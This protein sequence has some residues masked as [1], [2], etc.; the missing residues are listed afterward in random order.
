[1]AVEHETGPLRG[2][3]AEAAELAG[4]ISRSRDGRGGVLLVEG[5]P[6]AGKSRLAEE[7]RTFAEHLAIR[8]L[9]GTGERERQSVPFSAL[10]G[11]LASGGPPL[12]GAADLR[13]LSES[14]EHRFWLVRTVQD[15]LRQAA[16]DGPLLVVIDDLQWCDAGTLLAL[17]ILPARLRSLPI[18]WLLAVRTGSPGA[19]VRATLARLADAGARTMR[20]DRLPEDAVAEIARDLLCAEPGRD[21]LDLLR[22]AE[23]LPELVTGTVRGLLREGAVTRTGAV[24]HLTGRRSPVPSYGSAERLLGHLSPPAQDVIRLASSLGRDLE[25]RQ[26]ADLAGRTLAEVVAALQEAV[27]AGLVRPTDPL[28][29]RHDLLLGAL[30]GTAP[31]TV[32]AAASERAVEA[33]RVQGWDALTPAERRVAAL[34]ATGA[35]NRQAA[36]RLFL[37]PATVGTHVMHTFRK[38]GVNSRVE[39]ARAY[40]ERDAG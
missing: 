33:G 7:A 22:Q 19:D 10:L 28:T 24:A 29:F 16:L 35:T 15:R 18:R 26:L 32:P 3:E 6:G 1:M 20:L 13:T 14:P 9:R 17:R 11:T 27:D 21:V 31:K 23:G 30:G 2:R 5:H 38:L 39:L 40:L 12:P 36:E 25:A 37:S 34:V 4:W 8:V